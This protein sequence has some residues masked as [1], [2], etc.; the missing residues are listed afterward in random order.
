MSRPLLV[1]V[2]VLCASFVVGCS[3]TSLDNHNSRRLDYVNHHPELNDSMK[4]AVLNGKVALGMSRD[5]VVASWGPPTRIEKVE[6][7]EGPM[8]GWHYGNYFLEG[9]VVSLTFDDKVLRNFEMK[10]R[11]RE[12]STLDASSAPDLESLRPADPVEK[13]Q[14]PH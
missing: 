8:E 7:P 14:S 1:L 5:V 10:D 3:A 9:T 11:R 2:A 6:T 12:G 4:Q 13:G